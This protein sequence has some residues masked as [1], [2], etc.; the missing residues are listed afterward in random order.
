MGFVV[1]SEKPAQSQGKRIF[2][3]I[4]R[5]FLSGECLKIG[6]DGAGVYDI[7]VNGA[8]IVLLGLGEADV[9]DGGSALSSGTAWLSP[10][11]K[12]FYFSIRGRTFVTPADRV[13]KVLE[14]VHRKAPVFLV[15]K[16]AAPEAGKDTSD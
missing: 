1:R 6:I 16:T 8:G 9:F 12:G 11:R 10:S 7:S 2:D 15:H 4:G 3:R 14:G 5:M 13:R